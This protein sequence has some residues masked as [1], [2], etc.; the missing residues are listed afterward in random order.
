MPGP[1]GPQSS[2][3]PNRWFT[4]AQAALFA[5]NGLKTT[6][7]TT[8]GV[9]NFNGAALN[10]AEG[11]L[12]AG[13]LGPARTVSV[14][15][16]AVAAAYTVGSTVIFTGTFGGKVQTETLTLTQAGG[17][18]T[19]FGMKPFDTISS[20]VVGAQPN[21]TGSMTFG[22]GDVV[23]PQGSTFRYFLGLA[24]GNVGLRY[25]E[26]NVATDDVFPWAAAMVAPMPG[27]FTRLL[28]ATTGAIGV[29]LGY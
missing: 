3:V 16:A 23:A 25:D 29:S 5:A 22:V 9:Q 26:D 19:L 1:L 8:A 15:T 20:V 10:G 18:E 2:C 6:F 17:G 14:S 21:G 12:L 4:R 28:R 7:A 11:P 27:A 13:G 24:A